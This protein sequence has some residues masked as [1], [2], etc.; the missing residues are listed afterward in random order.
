MS[1]CMTEYIPF[2]YMF[3]DKARAII[4]P[5]LLNDTDV[6]SHV[7]NSALVNF[8]NLLWN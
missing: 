7:V 1:R 3:E 5:N 2:L 4:S 8:I 6:H